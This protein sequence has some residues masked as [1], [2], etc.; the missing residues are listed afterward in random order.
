MPEHN[1]V[2][3][4]QVGELSFPVESTSLLVGHL[5]RLNG[6]APEVRLLAGGKVT[7]SLPAETALEVFE[8]LWSEEDPVMA[9][10]HCAA[11]QSQAGRAVA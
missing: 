4:F 6:T 8:K 3:S 1:G 9:F 10:L 11:T 2:F 5:Q 7:V